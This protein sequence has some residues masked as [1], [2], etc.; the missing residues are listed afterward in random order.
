MKVQIGES[1]RL[2]IKA[3]EYYSGAYVEVSTGEEYSFKVDKDQKWTDLIISSDA[4]GFE[5]K[6]VSPAKR[7]VPSA[8]VFTLCGT[9]GKT[10]TGHFPVGTRLENYRVP[11]NGNLHFF[12]NDHHW[13][14]FYLNNHGSLMLNIKRLK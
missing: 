5:H 6:F 10:S 13:K 7:R 8:K 4:D 1:I 3:R 2:K 9:I 11:E 14:F 12:A